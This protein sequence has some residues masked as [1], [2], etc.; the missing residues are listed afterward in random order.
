[1]DYATNIIGLF[2]K[3]KR[4]SKLSTSSMLQKRVINN[5]KI[6]RCP[7]CP[8]VKII[9]FLI[10]PFETDSGQINNRG[11]SSQHLHK[12]LQLADCASFHLLCEDILGELQGE[13]DHQQQELGHRETGEEHASIDVVSPGRMVGRC[14]LQQV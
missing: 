14:Q 6:F 1:M 13:V 5:H 9:I 12:L 7:G 11:K 3:K 8:P 10:R 2:D 4:S